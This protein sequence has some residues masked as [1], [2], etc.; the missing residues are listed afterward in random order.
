MNAG[1]TFKFARGADRHLWVIISDPKRDASKLLIVNFTSFDR[2]VD[3]TVVLQAGMHPHIVHRT[4]V[5][6]PRAKV[7]SLKDMNAFRTAGLIEMFEPV[8]VELLAIIR[9]GA[10]K[11]EGLHA[12]HLQLLR[13]Q[14]LI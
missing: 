9:D 7:A 6:Y 1:D 2:F 12:E 11:S 8:S 5:A 10:G 4:C 13:E 3:Q 14:G